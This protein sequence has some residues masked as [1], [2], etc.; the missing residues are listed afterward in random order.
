MRSSRNSVLFLRKLY[1]SLRG[2][3]RADE[4]RVYCGVALLAGALSGLF[5]LQAALYGETR[6]ASVLGQ[7]HIE[8]QVDIPRVEPAARP[9]NALPA[10]PKQKSAA[11]AQASRRGEWYYSEAHRDWRYRTLP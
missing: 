4:W 10:E 3:R 2:L 1:V 6:A 11:P 9:A 5:L 8:L 7:K